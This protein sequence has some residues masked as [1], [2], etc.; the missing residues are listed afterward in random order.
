MENRWNPPLRAQFTEYATVDV[1]SSWYIVLKIRSDIYAICEPKHFQEVISFLIIGEKQ[2]LLWDTGMGL[3]PIMPIVKQ[4]TDKEV[5]AVNSHSHF[6]HTGGNGEFS[7]VWGYADDASTN[8]AE[9]GWKPSA[10]DENFT[11]QAVSVDGIDLE[12]YTQSGY[13]LKGVKENQI[14]DLGNSLWKVFHTPGHSTDSIVLYNEAEK[15]VLTG[16]TIYPGTIYA[17]QNLP[18]YAGTC[19]KLAEKFGG[20]TLLCSHNEPVRNGDFLTQVS[21]ALDAVIQHKTT[22]EKE[23]GLYL[24]RWNDI[25]ILTSISG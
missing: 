22:P 9:N 25:S 2:A 23:C 10:D 3:Y 17:Q 4:L 14:F 19:K 15:I 16:D 18:L 24:H 21:E 6:D 7:F 20:Y 5:V 8:I 12:N 1:N 13:T 11:Q